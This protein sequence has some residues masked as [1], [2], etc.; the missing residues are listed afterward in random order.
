M[1]AEVDVVCK[2]IQVC[3]SAKERPTAPGRLFSSNLRSSHELH[4]NIPHT[5]ATFQEAAWITRAFHI[6]H[7]HSFRMHA[8]P[9]ALY[10][11]D[12]YIFQPSLHAYV[13]LA[14]VPGLVLVIVR[15]SIFLFRGLRRRARWPRCRQRRSQHCSEGLCQGSWVGLRRAAA[16]WH[17]KNPL[18]TR[19]GRTTGIA[20]G[21]ARTSEVPY[22]EASVPRAVH[23]QPQHNN[24]P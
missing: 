17:T 9:W 5:N 1:C 18:S 24:A 3:A 19:R 12:T 21:T 11:S 6:K 15:L 16:T 4:F 2:C 20:P 22:T 7:Q 23:S 8:Y 14:P 13:S 10:T